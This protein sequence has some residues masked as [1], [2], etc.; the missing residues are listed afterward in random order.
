VQPVLGAIRHPLV[1]TEGQR[2]AGDD[3]TTVPNA[4]KGQNNLNP[5]LTDRRERLIVRT[6]TF[7]AIFSKI[8]S[9]DFQIPLKQLERAATARPLVDDPGNVGKPDPVTT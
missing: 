2:K 4:G 3:R 6:L 9:R 5:A 1:D 7:D 8:D